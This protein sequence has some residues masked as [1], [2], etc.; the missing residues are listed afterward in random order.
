ML[1]FIFIL[2]KAGTLV[3]GAL[4]KSLLERFKR[5]FGVPVV[6]RNLI[7]PIQG[8]IAIGLRSMTVDTFII[9]LL[10]EN[11]RDVEFILKEMEKNRGFLQNLAIIFLPFARKDVPI[12]AMTSAFRSARDYFVSMSSVVTMIITVDAV[13]RGGRLLFRRNQLRINTQ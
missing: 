9:K 10:D 12:D 7:E 8:L 11:I 1:I 3:S 4:F 13:M 5:S 2:K 6:P